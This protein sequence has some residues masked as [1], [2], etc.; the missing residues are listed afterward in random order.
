MSR[1]ILLIAYRWPGMRECVR[2]CKSEHELI[3]ASL[4]VQRSTNYFVTFYRPDATTSWLFTNL[5]WIVCVEK[6][7]IKVS[8]EWGSFVTSLGVEWQLDLSGDSGADGEG[9]G[10]PSAVN[11]F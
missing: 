10:G 1:A 7:T 11:C 3:R 4:P 5:K 8:D 9:N 2:E 6:R